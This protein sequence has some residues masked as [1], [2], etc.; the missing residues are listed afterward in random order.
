MIPYL[1]L[2]LC[3]TVQQQLH[4]LESQQPKGSCSPQL[5]QHVAPTLSLYF[6]RFRFTSKWYSLP[7]MCVTS[8]LLVS[9][10]RLGNVLHEHHC[11]QAQSSRQGPR[12]AVCC[13]WVWTNTQWQHPTTVLA[14][15]S[16]YLKNP[17]CSARSL[18]TSPRFPE[19]VFSSLPQ[20]FDFCRQ[21]GLESHSLCPETGF[22]LLAPCS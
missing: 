4:L 11:H 6:G 3:H 16:R 19:A 17:L 20:S 15:K 5:C 7:G 22:F 10:T 18:T 14:E 1:V 2:G 9:P 13:L 8:A 12:L 21:P